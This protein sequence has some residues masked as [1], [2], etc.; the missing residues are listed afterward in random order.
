MVE[1]APLLRPNRRGLLIA[2]GSLL[3]GVNLAGCLDGQVGSSPDTTSTELSSSA[4][5]TLSVATKT[6]QSNTIG[7]KDVTIKSIEGSTVRG[8]VYGDGTCGIIL[9]PQINMD[10]ESW[11]KEATRLATQG[12][13]VLTIDEDPDNRAASVLGAIHYL[14]QEQQV[15]RVNLIGASTGGEAVVKAN[16]KAPAGAVDGTIT[17]SAGGGEQYAEQLQGG[18]LFIVS[19]ADEERFV[20][21]ARILHRKAPQPKQLKLYSGD[22]HGQRLFNS[23]HADALREQI[24]QLI[25]SACTK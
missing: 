14:R 20:T 15:E 3:G 1:N 7:T 6:T 10:R 16:A 5:R 12:H 19:K 4:N 25:S 21:V 13:L 11:D 9:V 17:L 8:T 22:A 18:L 2:S 24:T 23:D